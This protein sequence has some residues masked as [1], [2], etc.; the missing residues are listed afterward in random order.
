MCLQYQLQTKH[1]L[2]DDQMMFILYKS[3]LYNDLRKMFCRH[4]WS[5]YTQRER[6]KREK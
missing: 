1:T 4:Y 6:N 2:G 5:V 3:R